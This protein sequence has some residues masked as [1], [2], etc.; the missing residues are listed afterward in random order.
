[1]KRY[2]PFYR[3]SCEEGPTEGQEVRF[4]EGS[5]LE[6]LSA[7]IQKSSKIDHSYIAVHA[8]PTSIVEVLD[9]LDVDKFYR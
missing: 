5:V 8:P 9:P 4:A 7:S 2:L 3:L 6:N 1:M